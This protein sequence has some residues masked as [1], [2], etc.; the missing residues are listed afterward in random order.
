[1]KKKKEKKSIAKK[2]VKGKCG[3]G[4]SGL[5]SGF[6]SILSSDGGYSSQSA[7]DIAE[8]QDG[9]GTIFSQ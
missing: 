8:W 6:G 4:G 9:R 1:M 2:K 5:V 3:G 7:Q